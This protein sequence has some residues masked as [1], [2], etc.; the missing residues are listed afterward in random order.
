MTKKWSASVSDPGKTKQQA[1]K[2]DR[3]ALKRE[4]D[5]EMREDYRPEHLPEVLRQLQADKAAH[6]MSYAELV[7]HL[8]KT[9]G[10]SLDFAERIAAKVE[11]LR[12]DDAS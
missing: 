8:Q 12:K 2:T 10:Y 7:T 4:T 11:D 9:E 5:D 1:S 6:Q 3:R